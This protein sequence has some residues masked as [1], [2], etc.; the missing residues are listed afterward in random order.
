MLAECRAKPCEVILGHDHAGLGNCPSALASGA[1]C[2]P[3]C[4]RGYLQMSSTKC[5]LGELTGATCV[6]SQGAAR[7]VVDIDIHRSLSEPAKEKKDMDKVWLIIAIGF[8]GLLTPGYLCRCA[9][10][11]AA[12][13]HCEAEDCE[14]PT[15]V[16]PSVGGASLERVLALA[17]EGNSGE[18]G[19]PQPNG[20]LEHFLAQ[21]DEHA[22]AQGET[23]YED[24]AV[25]VEAAPLIRGLPPA[26]CVGDCPKMDAPLAVTLVGGA[27][28]SKPSVLAVDDIHLKVPNERCDGRSV[29]SSK[30]TIEVKLK[31]QAHADQQQQS[32]EPNEGPAVRTALA[33]S[34]AQLDLSSHICGFSFGRGGCWMGT[35][36]AA[37]KCGGVREDLPVPEHHIALNVRP[38]P[39]V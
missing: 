8:A 3:E 11:V 12:G 36:G 1:V 6:R 31:G 5:W 25:S 26:A 29:P 15:E 21:L 2:Q 35:L 23:R 28:G 17:A 20:C 34:P 7:N 13:K 4:A 14:E 19:R 33:S 30:D 38:A 39:L 32:L 18:D 16:V 9:Q 24:T 37:L 10:I 27:S 22:E